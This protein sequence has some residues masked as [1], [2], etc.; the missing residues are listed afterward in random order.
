MKK[1][2][3]TIVVMLMTSVAMADLM[4]VTA[5]NTDRQALVYA[6]SNVLAWV[7]QTT[8]RVGDDSAGNAFVY[9]IPFQLPALTGGTTVSSVS[10]DLYA[11][12]KTSFSTNNV[13]IDVLGIRV[14]SSSTVLT[15]DA[16]PG[17]AILIADNVQLVNKDVTVPLEATYTLNTSYFQ[18][19]YDNDV[20]AAGKYVFLLLRTDGIDPY[21][22]NS[23]L[24][25]STSDDTTQGNKP[26]LNITT[27]P[28]PAT[29]GMLGLGALVALSARR[30]RGQ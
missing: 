15:N 11:G 22:S 30:L 18:D 28:E 1:N 6:T 8:A 29:V 2:I 12:T 20:N 16:T 17:S 14:S 3:I 25:Y 5:T 24:S 13:Y 23:Y 7:G 27:I 26:V 10:L 19:I 21:A 9:I 4:S